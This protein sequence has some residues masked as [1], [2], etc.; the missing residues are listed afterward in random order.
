MTSLVFGVVG[1]FVGSFFGMPE[2]GWVIGASLGGI[3]D[4]TVITTEGP[5]LADLKVQTSTWGKMIPIVYGRARVAG[6]VIW[7]S[8]IRE[9][10]HTQD[11]GKGGPQQESIYYTYA[12]D[13]AVSVCAGPIFGIRKIW[14]NNKLIYNNDPTAGPQTLLGN[15]RNDVFIYTGTESQLPDPTMEAAKGVGNVPAY[16]GQA[17]VVF[18]DFQLADYGNRMPNFE[19]E[20][21]QQGVALGTRQV[22]GSFNTGGLLNGYDTPEYKFLVLSCEDGIM[23]ICRRGVINFSEGVTVLTTDGRYVGKDSFRQR[24]FEL[25]FLFPGLIAFTDDFS[26]YVESNTARLTPNPNFYWTRMVLNGQ[27]MPLPMLAANEIVNGAT[28]S[29][30]KKVIMLVTRFFINPPGNQSDDGKWYQFKIDGTFMRSGTFSTYASS[31]G[32]FESRSFVWY[33]GKGALALESDYD[34]LWSTSWTSMDLYKIQPNGELIRVFS[35]HV[36]SSYFDFS[37]FADN[38]VAIAYFYEY[39]VAY[40]RY[41]SVEPVDVPLK[42]VV[43]DQCTRSGIAA[44]DVDATDLADNIIGYVIGGQNGARA[45]L[46]QLQ[47]A[48]F[49]DSVESEGKLKFKKRGAAPVVTIPYEELAAQPAPANADGIDPLR[50]TRMQES[51]LPVSVAVRYYDASS[52]YQVGIEQ[53]KRLIAKATQQVTQELAIAMTRNK[54]AQI[55]EVLMY[56]S[57]VARTGF[58]FQTSRKYAYLE[59]T[60]VVLVQTPTATYRMRIVRKNDDDGLLKFSAVSED[61]TIYSSSAVGG[62]AFAIQNAISTPGISK[63]EFMDIPILRDQDN[64]AGLYIAITGY[65]DSWKGAV[66]YRANDN[67]SFVP[68][69]TVQNK[70]VTGVTSTVLGSW[71]GQ[72]FI[73]ESSIVEVNIISGTLSSVPAVDLLSGANAALIGNEIVQ[74]RNAVLIGLNKYRLTGM[75]RGRFGTEIY[76]S[77]HVAA[78]RFVLLSLSGTLRINEGASAINALR[79]YKAV[80]TGLNFAKAGS[81]PFSNTARGLKPLRPAHF[82]ATRLSNNDWNLRWV[83]RTRVDG[84]WRDAVDAALGETTES[85]E[86]EIMNGATVVRTIASATPTVT[87]TAAQQNTDFGIVRTTITARLYQL[88]ATVGRS[89]ILQQT[90]P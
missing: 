29:A 20:I 16:R 34:Y 89:D 47:K 70:C 10:K 17:Y 9:T 42:D 62:S 43:I 6:N 15:K 88:S 28:V 77:S 39:F 81:Y 80:S 55:A 32:I 72:N 78:E 25:R 24:E 3:V 59:P 86:V 68:V 23:R 45:N 84:T 19:F 11:A 51:D 41:P 48:Y 13:A 40:T 35:D 8:D 53:S 83:R 38:G 46:S 85:Y 54:A 44:A 4:P 31:L 52:D 58:E 50:I 2:L 26:L 37:L 75:L 66:L 27:I 65:L 67:L 12:M 14:A 22:G 49:F 63:A 7:S 60:D 69:G 74:F 30:D 79:Y 56:D 1:A 21:V 71:P 5:R 64:D 61:A 87:Y 73:D 90:F 82:Y 18:T 36:A 33:A 76:A 57:H